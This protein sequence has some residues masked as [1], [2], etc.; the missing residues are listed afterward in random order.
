MPVF[1][2]IVHPSK[3]RFLCMMICFSFAS[4]KRSF[5]SSTTWHHSFLH[6][7]LCRMF[8]INNKSVNQCID[9]F[10]SLT[11]DLKKN[12]LM[13]NFPTRITLT[14]EWFGVSLMKDRTSITTEAPRFAVSSN[15][16]IIPSSQTHCIL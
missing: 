5:T 9:F 15:A 12:G 4:K 3:I 2:I 1:E 11:L 8:T 13:L 16:H 7:G 14:D 10:G 6:C